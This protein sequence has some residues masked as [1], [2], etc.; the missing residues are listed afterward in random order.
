MKMMTMAL[1]RSFK[2]DEGTYNVASSSS[3]SSILKDVTIRD[4]IHGQCTG[5]SHSFKSPDLPSMHR[6]HFSL[7]S[8]V[9]ASRLFD[10]DDNACVQ[11]AAMTYSHHLFPLRTHSLQLAIPSLLDRV[12]AVLVQSR[13][14]DGSLC[15]KSSLLC[16]SEL[17]TN[18]QSEP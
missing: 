8:Q 3:S 15:M 10:D 16:C 6:V 4:S 12:I 2:D 11:L 9:S 5:T 7:G 1:P 14:T 13:T 18:N 17:L